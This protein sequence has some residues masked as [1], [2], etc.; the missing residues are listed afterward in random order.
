MKKKKNQAIPKLLSFA[1]IFTIA[2]LF[3]ALSIHHSWEHLEVKHHDIEKT[4][5][6]HHYSTISF[7]KSHHHIFDPDCEWCTLHCS[8]KI[9]G[10]SSKAS[11]FY[12]KKPSNKSS[13]NSNMVIIEHVFKNQIPRAPPL[14]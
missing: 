11:K 5:Q 12:F 13:N 6:F 3:P 14:A 1:L 9:I 4:G 8:Q 2:I 7:T 10:P